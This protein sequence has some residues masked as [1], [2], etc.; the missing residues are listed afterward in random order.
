MQLLTRKATV[1]LASMQ[2]SDIEVDVFSKSNE[3][4]DNFSTYFKTLKLYKKDAN[5][6]ISLIIVSLLFSVSRS[7]QLYR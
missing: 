6:I 3:I 2:E 1:N 5:L 7:R 4:I